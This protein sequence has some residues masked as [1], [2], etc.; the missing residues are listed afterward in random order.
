MV[1]AESALGNPASNGMVLKSTTDGVRSW[2]AV[3]V[4][5]VEKTANYTA[6][7][8]DAIL[9]NTAGGAW[10][11]TLPPSPTTGS[12]VIVIDS[13]GACGTYALTIGRNNLKIMGLAENMTV[14]TSNAAFTLVYQGATYGWR[15]F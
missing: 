11:L 13:A 14:N 5:W 2:E 6:G 12:S 3:S 7:I 1:G 9:A 4:I 10:T 15:L 8:G